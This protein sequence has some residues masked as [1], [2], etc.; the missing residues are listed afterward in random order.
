MHQIELIRKNTFSNKIII[1][2]GQGRSGKN[3]ISI[4]LSTMKNVEKMRLD[5]QFDLIPRY[6]QLGKMSKDAALTALRLEADEKLF[7]MMIGRD[8][9]F[10]FRDYS[11]VF[12]QGQVIKYFKR[13]F[14]TSDDEAYKQIINSGTIF[15]EMTHDGLSFINLYFEA[16]K[17][18]LLFIHIFRDPVA[19]IIEQNKRGLGTRIGTDPK[20]LQLTY[21]WNGQSIPLNALGLEEDY[22][23]AN[24]IE[25]LVLMVDACFRNNLNGYLSLDNVH[26]KNILFLEF[27]DFVTNTTEN[28]AL[29]E[30][31]TGQLFGNSKKRIMKREKCPRIINPEDRKSRIDEI[32]NAISEKYKLIFDKLI[33]DYDTRIWNEWNKNYII[34]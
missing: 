28:M 25:R 19:N 20:E 16:F 34:K 31:F 27:E 1:I 26:K 13:I 6:F 7:Y 2:D 29:L 12:K 3:L 32:N 33:T 8:V 14:F 15:Q 24:P 18:R 4:L 11:G 17:E 23:K 30:N 9:N 22:I 10:R 5:S 21:V